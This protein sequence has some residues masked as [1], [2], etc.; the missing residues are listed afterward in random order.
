M[1]SVEY[2]Y[3]KRPENNIIKMTIKGHAGAAPKGKDIVCAAASAYAL[4]LATNVKTACDANKDIKRLRCSV[5]LVD[6]TG[7]IVVSCPNNIFADYLFD[8]YSQNMT[9]YV[10][11]NRMYPDMVS[12]KTF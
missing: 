1:I 7:E 12:L 11:L 3:E 9:G 4:Q 2:S 10:I 5:E 6:G 8:M